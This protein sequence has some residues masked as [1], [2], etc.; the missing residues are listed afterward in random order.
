MTHEKWG[1]AALVDRELAQFIYVREVKRFDPSKASLPTW[2]IQITI[3]GSLNPVLLALGPYFK[4]P[5]N[6]FIYVSAETKNYYMGM[7]V[8][9]A[10]S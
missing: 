7:K 8:N 2:C 10:G 1:K 4:G 6:C 3:A 5:K 9:D